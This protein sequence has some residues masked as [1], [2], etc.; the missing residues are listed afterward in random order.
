MIVEMVWIMLCDVL[1]LG[2]LFFLMIPLG[3]WRSAAFAV[4]KRNFVGYF[5]NPTGYVFLCL[6]V[7]LTSFF[8]FCLPDFF[9]SNL[10]NFDQLNR[11]LPAIMLVFI[12]AI[13]MSIW[14]EEKRQGTDE[15]L[16]TLPAA[17]FDIVM[18]K[19]LAAV[20]IFTVS[21]IFSQLSNYCVLVIL[22]GGDLD[23]GLLFATY[24]GYWMI[25]LAML[26][27]G[28]IAS[29]LT[30]NLTVGF[31]LGLLLNA[32][33]VLI[34]WAD[35]AIP[36]AELARFISHWGVLERFD[37]FG[38]GVLSL[39]PVSY[40][41]FVA[42][43][44]IYVSLVLIGRRHWWDRTVG[45]ANPVDRYVAMAMLVGGTAAF[46]AGLIQT[47]LGAAVVGPLLIFFGLYFLVPAGMAVLFHYSSNRGIPM[48]VHY[49]WRTIGLVAFLAGC[50]L[51]IE[52]SPLDRTIRGDVTR[53]KVSSLHD[54]TIRLLQNLPTDRPPVV[55]DAYIGDTIPPDYVRTRN[56]LISR[57]KE[58]EA[59]SGSRIQVNI[60]EG[61]APFSARAK[62]AEQQ[63]GIKPA[64]VVTQ[65]R[66]AKRQEQVILGAAFRN[67]PQRVVVPFFDYGISVEYELIRSINT[68]SKGERKTIGIVQTDANMLGRVEVVDRKPKFHRRQLIIDELA[69]QYDIEAVL[70]DQPILDT[71]FDPEN[72]RYAALL[73]VQPSSLSA[74]QLDNVLRAIRNGQPTAIFEDPAPLLIACPA[75]SDPRRQRFV[76]R[77]GRIQPS[78]P[79][80]NFGALA[81][82]LNI[83]ILGGKDEANSFY[84]YVVWSTYYP[85]RKLD[86]RTPAEWVFIGKETLGPLDRERFDAENPITSGLDELLF[87]YPGAIKP[88]KP[89]S[90]LEFVPLVDSGYAGQIRF[91]MLRKN[92]N[93]AAGLAQSRGQS[94]MN[95]T[96]A[97]WI[98]SKRGGLGEPF[99]N[100]VYVADADLLTPQFVRS[101]AK[102]DQAEQAVKYKFENITFALNIMD[103]LS[104][105]DDYIEIRK[106]KPKYTT[107]RVIERAIHNAEQQEEKEV[108][109]FEAKYVSARSEAE[110]KKRDIVLPLQTDLEEMKAWARVQD[111][112]Y[113][114]LKE[115]D[116][117]Q[118]MGE[119]DNTE[120]RKLQVVVEGL[121]REKNEKVESIRDKKEEQIE[122]LQTQFRIWSVVLPPLIVGLIVFVRRRLRERE[123]V[124]KE[125]LL[126]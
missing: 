46:V 120:N 29:F 45:L 117:Q 9:T 62:Q 26:A 31:I 24:F 61:V 121:T 2:V 86:Q 1:F 57:L 113:D 119:I 97:A 83:D 107:L 30:N 60:N 109:D 51:V 75:T 35:Q 99:V 17:D 53:Y 68:V 123:G 79:K 4:L 7:L 122:N 41:L 20:C 110:Q 56:E 34:S 8:A 6:F 67:G 12:P 105:D 19:Y 100:V 55:V 25:G 114:Q 43:I 91:D 66:G 33:L 38:R 85:Y 14:S 69:K 5:S 18:G 52:N 23:T 94:G 118:R 11:V 70:P 90:D 82:F 42:A 96:L 108:A 3:M 32:P 102:P 63:F 36:Y 48:L 101:R 47:I 125:R 111:P 81:D 78:L 106:R 104:G 126:V 50:I 93:N 98:H 89:G 22:T 13:T 37:S 124:S 39:A 54:D 72:S 116:L 27:V 71:V 74:P 73:I 77:Q 64:L 92:F 103:L 59:K 44:A 15:L 84:P 76:D 112:R 95:Y 28:M 87:P 16:L 88:D 58:F 40:F 65:H 21:L 80:G 49:L 115:R 10:A